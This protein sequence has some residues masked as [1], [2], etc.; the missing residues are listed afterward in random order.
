MKKKNKDRFLLLKI[1]IP[2]LLIFL[3]LTTLPGLNIY[4]PPPLVSV[5]QESI[6]LNPPA[7]IPI[8]TGNLPA[9]P[10]TAAGAIIIDLD[11][12]V[13]LMEKNADNRFA[14]AS[15]TKLIT[16]LVSYNAYKPNQIL[17]VRTLPNEGRLMGLVQ[18]ERISAENLIMGALIHSGNDAA[19]ALAQNYSGGEEAFIAEM[20]KLITAY[21]LTDTHFT[22]PI[23]FEDPAH[24]TTARDLGQ[25]TRIALHDLR[26]RKII[27]LKLTTVADVDYIRFHTLENVNTLL[28]KLPGLSGVKTGWTEE[29]GEVL[30]SLIKRN[31]HEVI[32][33][34]LKSQDRF[35]E[36]E[37]LVNWV[38][39]NF[40]W[41]ELS[42]PS[43]D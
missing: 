18:G 36:T 9:P 20:N 3:F 39:E 24:Y 32:I 27:S 6:K 4:E 17:E 40:A 25:I 19:L 31:G 30:S 37:K 11:S 15:T 41:V 12:Q 42:P 14:P 1:L 10:I 22:N 33:I 5:A 34:L 16:A 43:S 26:I 29:A 38:F 28:G 35:G 23:G 21:N 13:V 8:N 7:A 2:A